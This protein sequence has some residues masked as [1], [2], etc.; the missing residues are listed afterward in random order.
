MH[1][2]W[3][4]GVLILAAMDWLAVGLSRP[5]WRVVTKPAPML[6]LIAGFTLSSGWQ[7]A[8]SWFGIGLLAS[9]TGDILLMLPPS[10]FPAGLAAFLLAHLSYIIGLNQ[11][12]ILPDWNFIFPIIGLVL[13][14]ALGYRRLRCALL[15]RP[16]GRW[17][18]FPMLA[19]I[20]IISLMLFSSLLTWLRPDWPYEAAALVSVGA[21]LFYISD[22]VLAYNRFCGA[23]RFARVIVMATYHLGQ[24]AITAGVLAYLA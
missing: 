23:V 15:A 9:L 19:Y 24:L 11:S 4:A 7:G 20:V 12:F 10:L 8:G 17:V 13:L 5:H 16:S 14:D 1:W 21:L 18:R 22:T 6:V 3:I 2:G